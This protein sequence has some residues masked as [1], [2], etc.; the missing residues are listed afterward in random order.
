MESLN[1]WKLV[2]Y[3]FWLGVGFII[4]TLVVTMLSGALMFAVP[5][6]SSLEDLDDADLG[7]Q[8]QSFSTNFDQS[9]NVHILEHREVTNGSQLLVLGRV[10]NRSEKTISSVMIE[11]ELLDESGNLAYECSGYVQ[12]I[13]PSK[14]ENF[15]VACG[16][17]G[18]PPPAYKTV[19]VKVA[20]ASSL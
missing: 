14:A 9:E 15:Q 20:S 1:P 5:V 6:I 19:S 18:R 7:D 13:D 17:G 8:L 3:G 16:C 4:P 10:E 2:K 12:R 11:V